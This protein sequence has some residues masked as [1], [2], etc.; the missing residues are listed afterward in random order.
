MTVKVI[1]NI[2]IYTHPATNGWQL[3]VFCVVKGDKFIIIQGR[4]SCASHYDRN[5]G[6]AREN[7]GAKTETDRDH[8]E[9]LVIGDPN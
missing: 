7:R 1:V 9:G 3:V 8:D 6:F 2:I 5:Q 4:V